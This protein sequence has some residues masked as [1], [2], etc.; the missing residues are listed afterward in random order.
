MEKIL[1]HVEKYPI[2]IYRENNTILI[3]KYSLGYI[4]NTKNLLEK[5]D[6][7]EE[8]EESEIEEVNHEPD[9]LTELKTAVKKRKKRL[10]KRR[11]KRD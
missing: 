9:F 8:I 6:L 10:R 5:I 3:Y 1:K 11:N 4:Y 7:Q 2:T